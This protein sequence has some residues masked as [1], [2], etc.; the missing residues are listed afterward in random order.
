MDPES[1]MDIV[2]FVYGLS[3]FALALV[4]LVQHKRESRHPLAHIIWLLMM[5]GFVHS[6]L[7]WLDL[8]TIV[9][10]D[11]AA[12]D[13]WKLALLLISF[14]F[15]FEFGRRLMRAT[16]LPGMARR[17][18]GVPVYL[19]VA[20]GFLIEYWALADPLAAT[21]I[22][23]RHFLA[24]PGSA[25]CGA[26]FL[27]YFRNNVEEQAAFGGLAWARKYFVLAS[28]A[29]LVYGV[30]GGLVVP[31]ADM[32]PAHVINQE[33]FLAAFGFPVQLSR[34]A[35]ALTAA[36][37]IGN[38]LR[39][40]D[41]ETRERL[42]MSLALAEQ[43]TKELRA[44]E[45]R[46]RNTIENAPI[47]M[48]VTTLDGG[49]IQVNH[50]LSEIVGYE[51]EELEARSLLELTYP[52]DRAKCMAQLQRLQNG[53]LDSCRSESR[54]VRRDGQLIWVQI[55]TSIERLESGEAMYLIVQ[56]EDI[57][58]RKRSAEFVWHQAN[59]DRLTDLPNRALFFERLSRD[60]SQARRS[61]GHVGLLL[62]DLDG[63]KPVND[64]YGHEAGDVVLKTVAARWRAGVRETD[65]VARL[66]GDEFAVI[67][68]TLA[69]AGEA[70]PVAEKLV[71]AL[72][73]AIALP[74]GQE[75]RIG[76]SIGIAIYPDNATEMDSLLTAADAAMYQSKARGK[77]T[78]TYSAAAPA[79][80]REAVDWIR[81]DG[82]HLVG[83]AQIDDQHRHLV[84]LV[85]QLNRALASQESDAA[86]KRL[87]EGL[88][89]YTRFHFETEHRLMEK[90]AYPE[91]AAHDMEH[92]RL[93]EVLRHAA[94][95][96][97]GREL[98]AL[99]TTKDWL[100][101]HILGADRQLAAF[102]KGQGVA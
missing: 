47:G 13:I 35:C 67:M 19:A 101:G 3:F 71:Q 2:Y 38:I 97:Q 55:T 68:G 63:F 11:D 30:M 88:I 10:G 70:A 100:L 17:L 69:G 29:F 77:N 18:L 39:V 45:A 65:T 26:G 9:H 31:Q 50:A 76:A 7:E 89:E 32:F 27:L 86:L 72:A 80:M 54:H 90:Y 36:I 82:S 66:G 91:E 24:F 14:A 58:E 94:G 102:L 51:K 59:F 22:A 62:L 25:M 92:E 78:Y 57:T 8:W 93:L 28:A 12:I 53:E 84:L 20:L 98:L 43:R 61:G 99:Q 33:S 60:V 96:D 52:E 87:L 42:R 16:P 64:A 74:N 46:F 85:N 81:F 95:P 1:A 56:V 5:F 21:M 37:A 41:V 34:A 79:P 49:F 40:F 48:G 6:T 83:V 73:A 75:C 4:I 44:S 15:L 23:S